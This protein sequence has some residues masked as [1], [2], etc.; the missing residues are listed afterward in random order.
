MECTL[1]YQVIPACQKSA[2]RIQ[3]L[4]QKCR[5]RERVMLPGKK[6]CDLPHWCKL[7]YTQIF[8]NWSQYRNRM[9]L[10]NEKRP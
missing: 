7:E 10:T 8:V 4:P 6:K 5:L 1:K 3:A 2:A 9:M